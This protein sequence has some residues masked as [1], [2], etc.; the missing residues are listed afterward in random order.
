MEAS[1][2]VPFEPTELKF[3][4]F[5]SQLELPFYTALFKFKLDHGKLDDSAR[6]VLGTYEPNPG[7]KAEESARIQI[8][9]NALTNNLYVS[10]TR[11]RDLRELWELDRSN[12]HAAG[13]AST[14][15]A[16][17]APSRT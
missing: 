8:L 2:A 12:M 3:A 13:S 5:S 9:G 4:A 15:V 10:Q 6:F 7:A 17:R 16:P 1:D 11:S 14:S